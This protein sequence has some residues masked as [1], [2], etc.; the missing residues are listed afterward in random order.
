MRLNCTAFWNLMDRWHVQAEKA[1]T[2]IGREDQ[3]GRA[4]CGPRRV[5]IAVIPMAGAPCR[6]VNRSSH[7]IPHAR[8]PKVHAIWVRWI[9]RLQKLSLDIDHRANELG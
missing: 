2:L 8:P 6:T 7:R 3:S 4:G 1:L 9:A 5:A